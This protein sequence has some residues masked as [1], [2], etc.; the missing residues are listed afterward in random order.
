VSCSADGVFGAS[1]CKDFPKLSDVTSPPITTVRLT[2]VQTGDSVSGDMDFASAWKLDVRGSIRNGRL[3][4][5]SNG[6]IPTQGLTFAVEGWDSGL[7][8]T[9]GMSGD[10][11]MRFW[12]TSGAPSGSA[13][14]KVNLVNVTKQ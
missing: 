7:S 4:F 6:S 13:R 8:G 2:L 11:T 12:V 10:F 1:T 9:N 5:S 14:Y 3:S